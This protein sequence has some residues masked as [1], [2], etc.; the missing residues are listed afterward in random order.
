M[1][2][3]GSLLSPGIPLCVLCR[4]G[5]LWLTSLIKIAEERSGSRKSTRVTL[6]HHR[7]CSADCPTCKEKKEKVHSTTCSSCH[8]LNPP[9]MA[10]D[11][12]SVE[13]VSTQESLHQ[14]VRFRPNRNLMLKHISAQKLWRKSGENKNLKKEI[15]KVSFFLH[16][17]KHSSVTGFLMAS[18]QL[19]H[20]IIGDSCCRVCTTE[21]TTRV[22]EREQLNYPGTCCLNASVAAVVRRFFFFL[23]SVFF[24]PRYRKR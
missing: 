15:N 5:I 24:L 20:D 13:S 8:S 3:E 10:C 23:P 18:F 12:L 9:N 21:T 22:H 1:V 11:N 17:S 4:N 7:P 2:S 16:S 19:H 6:W 14:K